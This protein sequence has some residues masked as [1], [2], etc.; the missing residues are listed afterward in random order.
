[1]RVCIN[2]AYSSIIALNY[3]LPLGSASGA[4]LFMAYCAPMESVIP[5]GITINGFTDDH[6]IRRSFIKDSRDQ[7]LQSI[8]MLMDTVAAIAFWMDTMHLKLNPD[9]TEF[10]MFGYRSQLVKS[11]TNCVSISDST[12]PRSPSVKYLRVT[13]DEN[14]SL[15]EHI[16]LK[17]RKAMAKLVMICNIQKFLTKDACTTLVLGLCIS[18]L[19]YANTLFYGL[20]DKTIS[21]LQRIQAMCAK[22]TL[23]KSKFDSTIEALA[24]LHWL[25]IRQRINYK[26]SNNH[27]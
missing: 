2:N 20:P 8:L 16:L 1:M 17:C 3:S 23:E 21:H 26:K 15:K 19:D 18:H 24:Q 25:P 6:S 9:K 7:E 27:S 10:I 11:K 13:L 12:I 22:L 5:A 14:L 4:N